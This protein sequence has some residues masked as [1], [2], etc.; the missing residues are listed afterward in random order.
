MREEQAA[1]WKRA[2]AA[3]RRRQRRATPAEGDG[4]DAGG[5]WRTLEEDAL[6]RETS[7]H[8]EWGSI[9]GPVGSQ[10]F[11]RRSPYMMG[12]GHVPTGSIRCSGHATGQRATVI[13]EH[14]SV[15]G[16]DSCGRRSVEAHD[17]RTNVASYPT[18]QAWLRSHVPP[19]LV[20][21]GRYDLSF[22]VEEAEAYR[23]D[24]PSAEIHILDAGHFAL[25]EQPDT[26]D[27]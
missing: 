22:Q 3:R 1:S 12:F 11:I 27:A 8:C 19:L 18:W 17:Y 15:R 7:H 16:R 26:I 6:C 10:P 21:W 5:E 9:T 24:V 4:V 13:A 14:A 2:R 20:L 25:D 23:R